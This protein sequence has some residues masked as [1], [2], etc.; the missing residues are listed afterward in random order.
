MTTRSVLRLLGIALLASALCPRVALAQVEASAGLLVVPDGGVGGRQIGPMVSVSGSSSVLGPEFFLEVGAGR[1]DFNS[2]GQDYHHN[3]YLLALG[4]EWFPVQGTTRFGLR[5]GLGA[6]GEIETVETDPSS[7]G[8]GGWVETVVPGLVLER[9][10]GNGRGFVVRMSDAILGPW[11][12][13]L[14]PSEY[15]VDHRFM[16]L[17]GIRF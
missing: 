17:L 15:D 14:D 10:F 16:V 3:H 9:D 1:T 2:L 11:F 4:S 8:G 5:L 7:P 13:V 6:Y 12:A